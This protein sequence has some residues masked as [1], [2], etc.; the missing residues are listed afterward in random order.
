MP[1]TTRPSSRRPSGESGSRCGTTPRDSRAWRSAPA[2]P[3]ASLGL[4]VGDGGLAPS[5]GPSLSQ[6]L[7]PGLGLVVG[8][9]R[10]GHPR[11][12]TGE[13]AASLDDPPVEVLDPP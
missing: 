9:P 6:P 8:A 13:L 10:R 1:A 11:W 12:A 3:A 5:R 2:P 4:R 7:P